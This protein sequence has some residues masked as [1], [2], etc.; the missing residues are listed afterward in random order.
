[1]G[2][3]IDPTI[4]LGNIIGALAAVGSVVVATW[5]ISGKLNRMQW[6]LNLIWKWYSKEHG[7]DNDEVKDDENL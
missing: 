3:Q 6:K 2:F 5:R 7:I 4:S 1:M